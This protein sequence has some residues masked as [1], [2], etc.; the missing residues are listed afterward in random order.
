[1]ARGETLA[2]TGGN[3]KTVNC[4]FCH[5]DDL[6][7]LGPVPAIA[8]RP[9]SY[10]A[11]QLFDMRVG[12][13]KGAWSGLMEEAVAGLTDDDILVLSAYAASLAP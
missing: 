1:M 13:R 9:A 7:G 6:R 8:G 10:L 11:R 12:A 4:G 5:G 3:G 2:K